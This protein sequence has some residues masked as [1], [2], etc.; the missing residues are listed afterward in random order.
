[1]GDYAKAKRYG[2]EGLE[3]FDEINHRWGI[4]ASWCRVGLAELGLGNVE[5]A[6]DAFR[7]GMD[8]AL[9]NH[10]QNLVYYAL[11]G[12]GRVFAAE[13]KA[14]AAVRLLAH[15]VH[16]PQNPYVDLAQETLEDLG[17]QAT[18]ELRLSGS[19]MTLDGAVALASED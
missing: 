2:E 6:A 15:N 14:D 7:T 16:A 13:G 10:M 12:M 4:A 1:M 17:D 3:K 8:S 5:A 18:E 11:M 9:R 19:E